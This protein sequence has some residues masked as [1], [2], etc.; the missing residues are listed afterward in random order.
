MSLG[1]VV[2]PAAA[3]RLHYAAHGLQ[4]RS[5]PPELSSVSRQLAQ[6]E[7]LDT[8]DTQYVRYEAPDA[9]I[10]AAF[11]LPSHLYVHQKHKVL[12]LQTSCMRC[13]Y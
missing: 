9:V 7:L 12:L 5:M 1:M 13:G 2:L 3:A 11:S 4:F 8:P 10:N 6:R